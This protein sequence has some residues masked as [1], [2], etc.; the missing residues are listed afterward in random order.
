MDK[1][2]KETA[3][4]RVD[5]WSNM[6]DAAP[7][8]TKALRRTLTAAGPV[9]NGDGA[10]AKAG[11]TSVIIGP[12]IDRRPLIIDRRLV[13]NRT[14]VIDSRP[15]DPARRYPAAQVNG[16]WIAKPVLSCQVT[17]H[18]PSVRLLASIRLPA[19]ILPRMSLV[20]AGPERGLRSW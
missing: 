12:D 2:R 5:P 14:I 7:S 17:A 1:T 18:Q 11:S 4:V 3:E 13:I 10:S 9:T 8:K 19:G 15:H 20:V 16:P 6:R